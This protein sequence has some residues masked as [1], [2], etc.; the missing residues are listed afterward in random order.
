[1][2]TNEFYPNQQI[3]VIFFSEKFA[4]ERRLVAQRFMR[5]W[6]HGVRAY[7]DALTGDTIAAPG[8]DDIVR[9]MAE[10]FNLKP[11]VIREMHSHAVDASGVV[12]MESVQKDLDFFVQQGWVNGQIKASDV[13]DMSFANNANSELGAYQRKSK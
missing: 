1:M 4:A 3:S 11:E 6:L 9:I 12:R 8:S 2:D 7:N 10:S 13:V 5:A